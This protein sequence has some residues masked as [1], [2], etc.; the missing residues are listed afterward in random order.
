[1][2]LKPREE[3]IVLDYPIQLADRLLEQV[4]MKRPT[5]KVLRVHRI[6]GDQ[7]VDGEMKLFGALTG[8]RMEELEELDA[9]DYARLQETYVRFRTPPKRRDDQEGGA[10]SGK[11]DT[12]G[13]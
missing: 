5:M 13:A 8:L 1:M 12:L 3:I 9:A 2:A 6:K 10:D 4:T 7:D 11:A